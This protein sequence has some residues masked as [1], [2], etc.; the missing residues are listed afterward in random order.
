MFDYPH[1]YMA[2]ILREWVGLA[3][4]NKNLLDSAILLKAC[5]DILHSKPDDNNLTQLALK[6]K[7]IGLEW[8]RYA[9]TGV[10]P[11]I[12]VVTVAMSLALALDEVS[13]AVEEE[14]LLFGK[15]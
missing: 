13:S 1:D 12:N 14:G 2:Q 15:I 4:T 9:V 11:S 6:Y 3:M 7:Q 5:R 8:L 10:A